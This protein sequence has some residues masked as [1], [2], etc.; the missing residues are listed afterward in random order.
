MNRDQNLE[1]Q[2]SK[3]SNFPQET[4]SSSYPCSP[5]RRQL[6][7]Q[8][9]LGSVALAATGTLGSQEERV[10]AAYQTDEGKKNSVQVDGYASAT[11]K[12]TNW[13]KLEDLK[14]KPTKG[15][16]GRLK[17]SRITLGGNLIGG[18]AHS[19][20][21]IYVSDLVKA[22]HTKEKIFATFKLAEACGITTFITNPILCQ[23]MTEYWDKASGSID[24]ISDCGGDL[25]TLQES[26]QRSIDTGA[27]AC[28]VHGGLSDHLASIGN[29][30]PFFKTLELIRKNGLPAGI[31][32]H[33]LSTVKKCV[34]AGLKPD[35]WMKT[36]HHT[37]YWSA[38]RGEEC[39]NI[40]CREPNETIEYME[41]R[42]EPWIAF[43]VLAAGAIHPRDGFR[44]AFEAGADF[45]CVGMYDFQI[46]DDVNITVEILKGNLNRK[47]SWIS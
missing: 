15:K 24:F 29:F 41:S 9:F 43:K 27:V 7:A 17:M 16:I 13:A 30:E 23:I 6:L 25:A 32:A 22:Y 5:G 37:N 38:N 10:L 3:N 42:P 33:H 14:E 21:L 26:T 12:D 19:R 44:Y 18:W 4:A 40:F 47:R 35:F 34:E 20:D 11:R 31:G 8:M 46:V 39:D 2:N 36:L 28:Y 45:I 1:N